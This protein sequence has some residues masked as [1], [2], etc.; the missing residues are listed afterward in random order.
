MGNGDPRLPECEHNQT[1]P[2]GGL[3]I[4]TVA[5]TFECVFCALR[6]ARAELERRKDGRDEIVD[7]V[8]RALGALGHESMIEAAKR[9]RK[10]L[11]RACERLVEIEKLAGK[12]LG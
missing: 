1:V 7:E 8:R 4:V 11:N 2:N 10:N 12:P 5:P 3:V 6:D 9:V